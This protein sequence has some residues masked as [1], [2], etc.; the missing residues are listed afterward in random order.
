MAQ[1]EKIFADGFLF[2]RK[3]NAPDFVIGSQSI[4]ID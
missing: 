2:K 1:D 3:E 4:M